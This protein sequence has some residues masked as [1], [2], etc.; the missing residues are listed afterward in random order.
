MTNS[1]K[2]LSV[3]LVIVLCLSTMMVS[4]L[5]M[6]SSADIE[7]LTAYRFETANYDASLASNDPTYV[8]ANNA[9]AVNIV[10]DHIQQQYQMN[11]KVTDQQAMKDA[12]EETCEYYDG[13][14]SVDVSVNSAYTTYGSACRPTVSVS[15]M[16][17]P[18]GAK[19]A[20]TGDNSLYSEQSGRFILDVSRFMEE[21]YV[22]QIK[23]VYVQIQCYNWGCG[24]GLG[25]RPDVT[26]YPIKVYADDMEEDIPTIKTQPVDPNQTT[27]FK[28]SP[29]AKNDDNNDPEQ[30]H[31]SSDGAVWR[32]GAFAKEENYG[33]ARLTNTLNPREQVQTSFNLSQMGD[34]AANALNLAK[35]GTGYLKVSIT[36][37]SCVNMQGKPTIAEVGLGLNTT[38]GIHAEAP[39]A[40]KVTAWQYPG[41]TRTY[42]I[43]VSNIQH[44]SQIS[45][46]VF[47]V[48]NYWW[49]R[50][51]TNEM[52]DWNVESGYGGAENAEA[53]GHV[54]CEIKPV[55]IISPISVYKGDKEVA[56]TNYDLVLDDF[57][58]NGGVVPD[59]IT[60]VDPNAGVEDDE[61][62][63]TV[64]SVT[65]TVGGGGKV[66]TVT[67]PNG[68]HVH[69]YSWVVTKKAT[70][71]A[72][73]QEAFKCVHC[74]EVSR[75]ETI[76]KKVLAAPKVTVKKSGKK[77][78]V[79]YKKVKYAKGF[80][81]RY[82][83]SGKWK[84]EKFKTK[85]S[86]TRYTKAVKSGSYKVQV[87]AYTTKGKKTAYGKWSAV[88]KVKI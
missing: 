74:G 52:F 64:G 71:F 28:F 29:K 2:I 46:L 60:L 20:T 13:F 59:E 68:E 8:K 26:I 67:L 38:A 77:I 11:F 14:L 69:K 9:G 65:T 87:R 61:E 1:K 51:G 27:F 16:E 50:A 76:K 37:Q 36:L 75:T 43:D 4:S 15:L 49:Y 82:R 3:L 34:D 86:A 7:P 45:S 18:N 40:V 55:I 56:N 80:Q 42:Y 10:S 79:V 81:V 5:S 72:K 17:N 63:T 73:G 53:L 24:G 31:Y 30:L 44:I 54:K 66:T 57:N 58:Q 12:I 21:E 70:Y 88:K 83:I 62:T 25:T 41:T 19:I 48:Q 23:Y 39:P 84:L 35:Q 6:N 47:R 33:Y 22:D 78:K 32:S 85:K